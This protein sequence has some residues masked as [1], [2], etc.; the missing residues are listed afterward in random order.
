MRGH[1]LVRARDV[2]AAT[3]ARN[4]PQALRRLGRRER[5]TSPRPPTPSRLAA[6]PRPRR[7]TTWTSSRYGRCMTAGAGRWTS[8]CASGGRPRPI[9]EEL[10]PSRPR[11]RTGANASLWRWGGIPAPLQPTASI[12]ESEAAARSP[13][14][15]RTLLRVQ[16]ADPRLA[17]KGYVK[18]GARASFN[19]ERGTDELA[20]ARLHQR[21]LRSRRA[22]GRL[23]PAQ[24][25]KAADLA[26]PPRGGERTTSSRPIPRSTTA[27]PAASAARPTRSSSARATASAIGA[28]PSYGNVAAD[29]GARRLRGRHLRTLPHPFRLCGAML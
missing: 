21:R 8:R 16:V 7:R 3:G 22:G 23:H 19:F 5:C 24:P 2:P 25:R 15:D 26:L 6:R 18:A 17:G 11:A 10:S 9:P 29:G 14:G 1:V 27:S 20:G 12:R 4:S 13:G 28:P